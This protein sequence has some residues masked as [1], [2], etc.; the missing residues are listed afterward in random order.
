MPVS[1]RAARRLSSR[2]GAAPTEQGQDAALILWRGV[3]ADLLDIR[4]KAPREVVGFPRF[5]VAP[6]ELRELVELL[7]AV[8]RHTILPEP[9]DGSHRRRDEVGPEVQAFRRELVGQVEAQPRRVS[10]EALAE[11]P[12][13]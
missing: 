6:R 8:P 10:G 13:A 11:I 4:Y 12:E 5:R 3:P 1:R 7:D 9:S 2:S